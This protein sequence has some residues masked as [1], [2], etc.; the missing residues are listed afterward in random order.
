MVGLLDFGRIIQLKRAPD[1]T[2]HLSTQ[3]RATVRHV[4]SPPG[5]R[6]GSRFSPSS[7][8]RSPRRAGRFDRIWR[9]PQERP[10]A[11]WREPR[12][13]C[14]RCRCRRRNGLQLRSV[15]LRRSRRRTSPT[16]GE[17]HDSRRARQIGVA[18]DRNV[19]VE[20]AV[21]LIDQQNGRPFRR[22]LFTS[23][24]ASPRMWPIDDEHK[25]PGC[26]LCVRSRASISCRLLGFAFSLRVRQQRV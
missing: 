10:D 11:S 16:R 5:G 18:H 1:D 22:G 19:G 25:G 23:M 12:V 26:F 24:S 6:S 15:R 20:Y 3:P 21:W 9:S 4:A 7:P 17:R 14:G 2:R 13:A 8:T